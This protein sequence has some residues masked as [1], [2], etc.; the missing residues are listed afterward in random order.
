MGAESTCSHH[1]ETGHGQ[2]KGK[3]DGDRLICTS[4]RPV[5]S[6]LPVKTCQTA[7][8]RD[9]RRRSDRKA[10]DRMQVGVQKKQG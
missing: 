2:K 3:R 6:N 7:R 4:E 8:E 1:E 9:E 5:G 10:L